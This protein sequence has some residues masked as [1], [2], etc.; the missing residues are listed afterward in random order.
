MALSNLATPGVYVQEISTLPPSIAPVSTAIPAF[1]GYTEKGPATPTRITSMIEYKAIFGGA[2]NESY[3]V[4]IEDGNELELTSASDSPYILYYHLLM[5]FANGGGPCHII[6]VGNY[7][8][9]SPGVDVLDFYDP[10]DATIGI[11]QAELVDEVT[12]LVAPEAAELNTAEYRS[13]N[14]AMLAQCE[15]LKDRFT[16]MDVNSTGDPS[17]DALTF[18]NSCRSEE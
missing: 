2:F 8:Y 18:R 13:V 12:L 9:S 4:K 5:Y 14:D 16:I 11:G 15:K 7:S 17:A 3:T 6:Y 1:I 10:S